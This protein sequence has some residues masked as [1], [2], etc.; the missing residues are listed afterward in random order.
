MSHRQAVLSFSC[1]FHCAIPKTSV[2]FA[3]CQDK[4]RLPLSLGS[5]F[6]SYGFLIAGLRPFD[7]EN[8]KILFIIF[9]KIIFSHLA[10]S[11]ALQTHPLC[12]PSLKGIFYQSLSREAPSIVP[13]IFRLLQI[14]TIQK[15]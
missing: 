7:A 5:G 9:V 11:P 3:F 2:P 12:L 6:S 4:E 15:H 8:G 10:S 13:P 14:S 1:F